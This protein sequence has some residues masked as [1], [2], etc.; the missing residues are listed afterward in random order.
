MFVVHDI[1]GGRCSTRDYG[2]VAQFF[3]AK[4]L[5]RQAKYEPIF[6]ECVERGFMYTSEYSVNTPGGPIWINSYHRTLIELQDEVAY[7]RSTTNED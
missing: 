5:Y 1:S 2:N 7:N 6:K 4:P 3:R